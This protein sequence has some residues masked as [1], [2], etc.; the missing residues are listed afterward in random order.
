[1]QAIGMCLM[2]AKRLKPMAFFGGHKCQGPERHQQVL[3]KARKIE[4]RKKGFG[5]CRRKKSTRPRREITRPLFTP[6]SPRRKALPLP[7]SSLPLT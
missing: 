1:M 5:S 4:A 7:T 3:S 6:N 2:D